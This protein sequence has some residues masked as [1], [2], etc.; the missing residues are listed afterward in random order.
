MVLVIGTTS[1]RHICSK[2]CAKDMLSPYP[3]L[4][5]DD[6]HEKDYDIHKG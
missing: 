3:S 6:N 5:K 1:K 4:S 2:C